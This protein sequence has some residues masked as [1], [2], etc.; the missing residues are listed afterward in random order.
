MCLGY[1]CMESP[2][3]ICPL[4]H[5]GSMFHFSHL[6]CQSTWNL[7]VKLADILQKKITLILTERSYAS[8][9]AGI[10][11]RVPG[12]VLANPL[13]QLFY[14]LGSVGLSEA[15]KWKCI[16]EWTASALVFPGGRSTLH[17]IITPLMK[18]NWWAWRGTS[19][20]K[21]LQ[22]CDCKALLC[23]PSHRCLCPAEAEAMKSSLPCNQH[24]GVC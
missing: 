21:L 16:L 24:L 19:E 22:F 4:Y 1:C 12:L 15:V 14:V 18:G 5:E 20:C 7:R 3:H 11:S 2:I 8:I 17:R 13:V 23:N 9:W 10:E 6:P